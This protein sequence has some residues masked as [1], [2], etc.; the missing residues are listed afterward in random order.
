MNAEL[1]GLLGGGT[2]WLE[3][4]SHLKQGVKGYYFVPGL[5]LYLFP[6][7]VSHGMSHVLHH[8]LP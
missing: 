6:P 7:L 2:C 8:F 4:V 3:E 1:N 5:F